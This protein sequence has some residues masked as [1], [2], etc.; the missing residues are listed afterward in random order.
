MRATLSEAVPFEGSVSYMRNAEGEIGGRLK[1]PIR[2]VGLHLSFES[3]RD[4]HVLT[5]SLLV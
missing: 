2:L 1:H 4:G 5:H 3:C